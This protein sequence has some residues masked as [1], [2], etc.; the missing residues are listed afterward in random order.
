MTPVAMIMIAAALTV[1]AVSFAIYGLVFT[2]PERR[3]LR[4]RL[5]GTSTVTGSID[6]GTGDL[7]KTNPMSSIPSINAFLQ[8]ISVSAQLQKL[9]VQAN[10]KKLTVSNLL[11]LMVALTVMT[12][13]AVEWRFG[14]GFPVEAAL[15]LGLGVGGT[16]LYLTRRRKKHFASFADQFPGALDM[17]KSSIGAGHSLNYALEVATDEL[18]EPIAGELRI[19]LDE[20]RLGLQARDA[21]SNLVRRVPI[22]ELRFFTLAVL[23]TR[24][25]GGNLS[26]VLG[27]LSNTLRERAKLRQQVR[28]LSAQGR[29]SATMLICLPFVVGAFANFASPGYMLPLFTTSSGHKALGVA[30]GLQGIALLMVRK[31]CNPKSLRVV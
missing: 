22:S 26:E 31:I 25:V 4:E 8:S 5:S 17:I 15:S 3:E 24:E 21:L 19:V 29:A 14:L 9:L 13:T 6:D 10:L 18:P 23:L 11:Y 1:G 20:I 30:F 16:L 27:N 2:L 7:L 12:F 28:A